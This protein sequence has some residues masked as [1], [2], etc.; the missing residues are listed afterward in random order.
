VAYRPTGPE[1]DDW[2][3]ANPDANVARWLVC[4]QAMKS[5]EAA[6]LALAD[7]APGTARVQEALSDQRLAREIKF[8][9]LSR[10][11]NQSPGVTE[12]W[13]ALKKPIAGFALPE[14]VSHDKVLDAVGPLN[15]ALV[16][17]G[18]DVS[19]RLQH[20]PYLRTL[21]QKY[22]NAKPTPDWVIQVAKQ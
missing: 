2:L 3:K 7:Q 19:F 15:A 9:G 1:R 6:D 17:F 10:P 16:Y 8:E 22:G 14:G 13:H 20:T 4:G 11:I 18:Y 5:I 21:L 12:A